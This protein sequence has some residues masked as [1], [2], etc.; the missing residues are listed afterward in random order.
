MI[1]LDVLWGQPRKVDIKGLKRPSH[2]PFG[3]TTLQPTIVDFISTWIRS[4]GIQWTAK[5]VKSLKVWSIQILAGNRDY[6]EPWFQVSRYKGY[7]IPKLRMFQLLVDSLG[8]DLKTIRSILIVLNSYKI[9]TVG[10]P[11]LD[12]IVNTERSSNTENYARLTRM[13]VDLPHVPESVLD[14]EISVSSQRKFCDNQGRTFNGPIGQPDPLP[15]WG[16]N[17]EMMKHFVRTKPIEV[18]CLGR[19][20]PIRDKG[21]YRNILVGNQILQLATKKLADWLRRW[22]WSLPEIASGDQ[23]KMSRFAIDNL[24]KGKFMLSIDLSEATDRLSRDFQIHLLT[25]MGIPVGYLDFLNLPFFYDP[26]LFGLGP[27]T[28]LQLA[29]YSNGQPMGLYLSFPMFELSHYVILQF[30]V[31]TTRQNSSFC[32]CGDDVMVACKNEAEGRVVFERYKNLVEALG[33]VISVPKTLMSF[34]AAEGVGAL[35]LKDYPKEIRIPSGKLSALEAYTKET[36][37]SAEVSNCST[38]GRALMVAWLNTRYNKEYTYEMRKK[39]NFELVTRDLSHLNIMALRSLVKPDQDPTKFSIEDDAHYSFWM[40]SPIRE[41]G[42][43][44]YRLVGKEKFRQLLID[45]KILQ[46]IKGAR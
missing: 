46:L 34:S 5:R 14:C 26:K 41:A 44:P 21:K 37:V 2:V 43:L 23:T 6:S 13:Y 31:A 36:I 33:G 25:L 20:V 18:T 17:P 28:G 9:V 42:Q 27:E 29:E 38:L 11:S 24:Q 35:F 8:R 10:S 1:E 4:S 32:I 12:S 40:M 22:L 3:V 15:Q 45:N 7:K 30:A 16:N 39:A 19:L